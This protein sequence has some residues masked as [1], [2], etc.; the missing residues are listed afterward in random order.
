[1]RA[2][3]VGHLGGRAP[4]PTPFLDS[5]AARPDAAVWTRASS[6]GMPTINGMFATHCSIAPHSRRFIT[7]FTPTA[8]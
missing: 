1:M 6:F 2:A 7:S 3:D 4:S 8:L 5:L